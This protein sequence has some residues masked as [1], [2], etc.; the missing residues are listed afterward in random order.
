MLQLFV[1][2]ANDKEEYEISRLS[3]CNAYA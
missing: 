2:C 1:S 3:S